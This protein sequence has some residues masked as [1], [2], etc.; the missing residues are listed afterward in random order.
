MADDED[1]V[2]EDKEIEDKE[3]EDKEIEDKEIV[4]ATQLTRQLLITLSNSEMNQPTTQLQC[5][6]TIPIRVHT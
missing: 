5:A 2:E 4:N 6:S 1:E 3:I